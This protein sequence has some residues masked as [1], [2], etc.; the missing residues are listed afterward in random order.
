MGINKYLNI[1]E[2][3]YKFPLF[4]KPLPK[5]PFGKSIQADKEKYLQLY[6]KTINNDDKN[7][8]AFEKMWFSINKVGLTIYASYSDSN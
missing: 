3:I 7:V 5:N 8:V 4:K 6:N 2:G 1:Y